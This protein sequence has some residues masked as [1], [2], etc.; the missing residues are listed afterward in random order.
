MPG[1]GPRGWRAGRREAEISFFTRF[2][3]AAY[4]LEAG[5][6][7]VVAPWSGFWE[8]NVFAASLP[9]V[10]RAAASAFVRGGVSGIG[11]ITAI[12]GFIELAGMFGARRGAESRPRRNA[13]V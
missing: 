12:A 13:E 3:F 5:L 10:E 1:P 6:V 9:F 7:L 2:L 4:F 11:A 8:R